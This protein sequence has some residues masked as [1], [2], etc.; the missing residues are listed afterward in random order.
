MQL[1]TD[2]ITFFAQIPKK[3]NPFHISS[4]LASMSKQNSIGNSPNGKNRMVA[5]NKY[6]FLLLVESN[7]WPACGIIRENFAIIHKHQRFC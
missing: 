1:E 4:I 6:D 5:S 7:S 2:Q 3:S